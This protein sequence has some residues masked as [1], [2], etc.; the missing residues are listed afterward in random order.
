MIEMKS[1]EHKDCFTTVMF[2]PP[3]MAPLSPSKSARRPDQIAFVVQLQ[4]PPPPEGHFR[5]YFGWVC[6]TGLEPLAYTRA[7]SVEFCYPILD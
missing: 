2:F 1:A 3:F 5:L 7:S 6:A 4:R